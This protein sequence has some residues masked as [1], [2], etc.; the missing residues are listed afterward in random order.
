MPKYLPA[1]LTQYVLNY[2]PKNHPEYHV[3]PRRP[4]DSSS[5]TLSGEELR[6]LFGS[7]SRWVH[8][9]VVG[10]ALDGTLSS[11][12]GTG[13]YFLALSSR[14]VAPLGPP[15]P[16]QPLAPLDAKRCRTTETFSKRRRAFPGTPLWPR[17]AR[18]LASPI[19]GHL[20]PRRGSCF[21]RGRQRSAVAGGRSARVQR[22][23]GY[24]WFDFGMTRDLSNFF[25]SPARYTTPTGTIRGSWCPHTCELSQGVCSDRPAQRRLISRRSR[26][27]L[28]F[29]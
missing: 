9:G 16:N 8:R 1:G 2:F 4:F 7:R 3:T 11:V 17:T 26:G 5:R 12:E 27:W 21:G 29:A 18:Q 15:P 6:T 20:F 23:M 10:D 28:R 24:L 14:R 19:E 13:N 22:R 25:L